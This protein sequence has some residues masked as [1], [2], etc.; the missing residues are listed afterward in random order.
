MLKEQRFPSEGR[1]GGRAEGGEEKGRSTLREQVGLRPREV[2]E[3]RDKA[4]L[5]G[6]AAA[7]RQK[8][9]S[10]MVTVGEPGTLGYEYNISSRSWGNSCPLPAHLNKVTVDWNLERRL[11]RGD[12][13]GS[14]VNTAPR[15]EK[16]KSLSFD[17]SMENEKIARPPTVHLLIE[18]KFVSLMNQ[19][20]LLSY[21]V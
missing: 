20:S 18:K 12:V 8:G 7:P 14:A 10:D 3:K 5:L 17:R 13:L 16:I 11:S 19:I 6:G 4:C 9:R 2:P 21:S 1:A 15:T